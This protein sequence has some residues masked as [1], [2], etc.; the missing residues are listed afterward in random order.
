MAIRKTTLL[1]IPLLACGCVQRQIDKAFD[2]VQ[3]N[4]QERLGQEL[5]WNRDPADEQRVAD[6]LGQLL[7]EELTSDAAVRIAI[8]NNRRLQATYSDVGVAAAQLV[9]AW[10][11][12]NPILTGQIRFAHNR[13]LYEF[14]LVQDF[15]DVLL[16]PLA[17]SVAK[18]ELEATKLRV[19]AEVIDVAMETRRTFYRY[20]GRVQILQYWQS[21]LLASES[22]YEMA[23]QL[24]KAGNIS[25][26]RL[27][28]EQAAYEQLKLDVAEAE[29]EAVRDRERLNMLMGLWGA[30]TTWKAAPVLPELPESPLDLDDIE[31]RA[32]EHSLDLKA[33]LY[34]ITAEAR[35]LGL[36][37]IQQVIP[38]LQLGVAAESERPTQYRLD[39]D[40]RMGQTQYELEDYTTEEWQAGPAFS[41]PIPVWNLGQAAY[42][43][44]EMEILRRWNLYTALAVDIRAAARRGALEVATAHQRARFTSKVLVPVQD[45]VFRQ[46]ELQYNAMFMGVFDLLHAKRRQIEAYQR[47][48]AALGDYWIARTELEQLLLGSAQ[49]ISGS[50]R[51]GFDRGGRGMGQGLEGTLQLVRRQSEPGGG[52]GGG[53]GGR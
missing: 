48:V 14:E 3:Q 52:E 29:L 8:V 46:T 27:A 35:R 49:G 19:S 17:V 43:T 44:A 11:I 21:V 30:A 40:R 47:Y 45:D 22:A 18:A 4:A 20:E 53:P 12:K 13:P 39:K 28:Q 42:G 9:E 50:E 32:I 24:R 31:R 6:V 51:R 2:S 1:V 15:L 23:L 7:Q 16:V 33:A 37:S 25:Q 41:M 36:R 26:L 10:L 38:Q 34:N 5:R